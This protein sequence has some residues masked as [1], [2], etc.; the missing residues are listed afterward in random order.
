[1][2]VDIQSGELAMKILKLPAASMIACALIAGPAVAQTPKPQ[3]TPSHQTA[4]H[5]T[6]ATAHTGRKQNADAGGGS[7][8]G[9]DNPIPVGSK[10]K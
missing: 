1:M 4:G 5:K 9:I 7:G 6:L 8:G 10:N 2:C 3:T